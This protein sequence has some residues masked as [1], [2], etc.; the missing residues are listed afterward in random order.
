LPVLWYFTDAR[1]MADPLPVLR[2]L[3][4]GLCGVVFRHD[5]VA[6]R[7]RL[8]AQVAAVCRARGLA[9]VVA[10]DARLAAALQAGVHLRGG[11][12]AGYLRG[13]GGLVTSSAH[14]VAQVRRAAQAGAAIIFISPVFETASHPGG[15]ALGPVRWQGLARYAGTGTAYALGGVN[16]KK[17]NRLATSCYGAGSISAFA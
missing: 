11:R 2:G 16:G 8:G 3:P 9:L 15:R 17:I 4:R 5:G 12:R 10:G 1:R 7:A 6:G 14:D 13:A